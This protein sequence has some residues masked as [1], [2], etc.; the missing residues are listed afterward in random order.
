ML[1]FIQRVT[2][3]HPTFSFNS[4]Q[5]FQDPQYT[6]LLMIQSVYYTEIYT[7]TK[8][9][10]I[11]TLNRVGTLFDSHH[12]VKSEKKLFCLT[13]PTNKKVMSM[14]QVYH[15]L[16]KRC[17]ES[18]RLDEYHQ[19]QHDQLKSFMSQRSLQVVYSL[20]LNNLH[21]M[22]IMMGGVVHLL[23]NKKQL[24]IVQ[25]T[26]YTKWLCTQSTIITK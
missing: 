4:K 19:N 14:E 25:I 23:R 17:E 12:N 16:N 9:V 20:I 6:F 5:L 8:L 21:S 7:S 11:D 2:I 3:L 22:R 18:R 26:L 1:Q 15:E 10:Y 24:A 13:Q